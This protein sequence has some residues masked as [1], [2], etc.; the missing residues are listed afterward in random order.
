VRSKDPDKRPRRFRLREQRGSML[1]EV[2]VG[3]IVLAIAAT[4]ILN[5]IDGAQSAGAKNKAKSVQSSLAQQD[6]ERMRALPVSALDGLNQTRTV[7]VGGVDYTVVSTTAWVSDKA[8]AVNCSATG[9]QADYL[10]LRTSVTSPATGTAPVVETGLLTPSVGQSSTTTGTATVQ[11]LDRNNVAIGAGQAVTLSGAS[12]QSA[13]TNSAGCAVFGSIP[14]GT[15]TISVTGRVGIDSTPATDSMQVYPG[16]G[17]FVPMQAERPA[18]A[19]ASFVR[20]TGQTIGLATATWDDITVEN[21]NL[22]GPGGTKTFTGT[23][24]ATLDGAGLFPYLDGVNVWAGDCASND[25]SSYTGQTNYFQ[26]GRGFTALTPATTSTVT[27]QMPALRV[28]A[29]NAAGGS[30]GLRATLV[31]VAGDNCGTAVTATYGRDT[32][33][34]GTHNADFIVPFGTYRVCVDNGA[35]YQV[36]TS[37]ALTAAPPLANKTITALSIPASSNFGTCPK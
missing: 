27:V 28:P 15:Y 25:P 14:I 5:G 36:N 32:A 11:V 10:K 21:G 8:G 26:V 12:T 17:T 18:T 35:R 3:A 6:I 24:A 34:S 31:P 9:A 1:V 20:P 19:R 22:T 7:N 29:T 16:R 23:K 30:W 33:V 13:N 37:V 4:A 2:M